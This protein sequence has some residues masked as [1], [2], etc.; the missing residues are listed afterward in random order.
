LYDVSHAFVVSKK[1]SKEWF[2]RLKQLPPSLFCSKVVEWE[3]FVWAEATVKSRAFKGK[4]LAPMLVPYVD[5]I[6]HR[7][8]SSMG[9]LH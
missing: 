4:G 9:V 1:W 7:Y 6:N 8:S 2:E 3:D 5:L